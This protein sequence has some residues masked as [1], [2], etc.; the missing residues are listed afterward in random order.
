MRRLL[1]IVLFTAC[2]PTAHP[3]LLHGELESEPGQVDPVA[4]LGSARDRVLY[5]ARRVVDQNAPLE[6]DGVLFDPN[7]VGFIQAAFW[8]AEMDILSW[9]GGATSNG[10]EH[11][12]RRAKLVERGEPGDLVFLGA[13]PR[14]P[15]QVAIA[16]GTS[17]GETILLGY[18]AG[19]PMR[20]RAVKSEQGIRI[21][22]EGTS[23]TWMSFSDPY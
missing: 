6:V 18:F 9:N 23:M 2:T 4:K 15:D 8:A 7:P 19:G 22:G 16:E 17:G 20:V 13:T 5:Q 14:V 12:Y 21:N 10:L 3:P 1:I 11:L